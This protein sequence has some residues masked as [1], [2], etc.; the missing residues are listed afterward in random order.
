[1]VQAA[2]VLHNVAPT[3]AGVPSVVVTQRQALPQDVAWQLSPVTS[4]DAASVV[5]VVELVV[6]LVDDEVV[7]TIATHTGLVLP[8]CSTEQPLSSPPT[9]VQPAP[10]PSPQVIPPSAQVLDPDSAHSGSQTP[11]ATHVAGAHG[12]IPTHTVLGVVQSAS[13]KQ[14]WTVVVVVVDVDVMVVELV[15]LIVL[16]VVEV[17]VV[18]A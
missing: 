2:I 1:V 10:Q 9:Q 15:E 18:V 11:R 4:H 13:A 5:V 6:V 7:G 12:L 16:V 3:Q 14:F 8:P 17:L